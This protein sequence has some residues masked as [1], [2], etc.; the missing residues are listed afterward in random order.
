MSF[1]SHQAQKEG[2]DH[3]QRVLGPL[4]IHLQVLDADELTSG[5]QDTIGLDPKARG[6]LSDK[7]AGVAKL[8]EKVVEHG[9]VL[10]ELELD[11]SKSGL[12]HGLLKGVRASAHR[13]LGQGKSGQALLVASDHQ[14]TVG[15]DSS[16][17][18]VLMSHLFEFNQ[19]AFKVVI[20]L[21]N[22]CL[23]KSVSKLLKPYSRLAL[24]STG[25]GKMR[26]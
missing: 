19:D 26:P 13:S 8:S 2:L 10:V 6:P 17:F 3:V 1:L 22:E 16:V 4:Q 12:V 21:C 9:S 11:Q 5:Y 20:V 23:V 7:E 14:M 15:L 18:A 24:S 25:G